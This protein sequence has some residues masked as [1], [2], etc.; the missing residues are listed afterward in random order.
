MCAEP[1][2]NVQ[3]GILAGLQLGAFKNAGK[4]ALHGTHGGDNALG[5]NVHVDKGFDKAGGVLLELR[6]PLYG[7][8]DGAFAL[9]Q[10]LFLGLDA[11]GTG[12]NARYAELQVGERLVGLGFQH[13]AQHGALPDGC[14]GNIVN[15]QFPQFFVQDGLG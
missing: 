5:V 2:A 15:A 1:W 13:A 11:I 3:D 12:R 10:G 4:A 14:V 8:V 9:V 7:R 6:K